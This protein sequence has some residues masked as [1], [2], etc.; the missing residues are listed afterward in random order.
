MPITTSNGVLRSQV[1]YFNHVYIS[2][3]VSFTCKLVFNC[4]F[5]LE[6]AIIDIKSKPHTGSNL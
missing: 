1:P 3:W 5:Y 6:F 2:F 4:E